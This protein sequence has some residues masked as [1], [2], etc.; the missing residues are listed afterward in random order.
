MVKKKLLIIVILCVGLLSYFYLY[1]R[2]APGVDE[3]FLLPEGFQGCIYIF[4]NQPGEE[5]LKIVDNQV[6]YEVPENGRIVT[7][8][9]QNFLVNLGWHKIYVKYTNEEG[10][11]SQEMKDVTALYRGG[12]STINIDKTTEK[13]WYLFDTSTETCQ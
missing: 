6:V 11:A 7:S 4:H 12:T 2:K 9:P 1:D 13:S 3:V 5:E 10:A 8:S